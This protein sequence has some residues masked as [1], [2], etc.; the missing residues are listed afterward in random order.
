[1]IM[2]LTLAALAAMSLAG[3]ASAANIVL[4]NVDP[5]N[6]GFNDPTPATPVGGNMGTTVGQQRLIAYQRALELWGK[7]LRSDVPIVVRGS[8]A[9]LT[10]NATGGTLAQ[11]G[12][13]QVFANFPNA[14]LVDHWYGVA[15][16][17]SI[18]G[19]DLAPGPIDGPASAADDIVANFN[20]DVGKADCIAGP[21]WYY[22]LDSNPGPGQ[23]DFLDVFMHEV[24]HGLG[25]QNFVNEQTGANLAGRTDVYS[26]YTYD[27]TQA[28]LWNTMSAAQIRASAINNGKVVWTGPKVN[29][30]APLVLGPYEGVR[31]FGG[32]S[33]ELAFG[34]ATFGAAPSAATLDGAIVVGNDGVAGAGGGTATDGCE[35][36]AAGSLAGKV[37]LIDRGLC[38]FAV[39]VKNAQ[40]AGA[41]AVILANTLGRPE[42]EP[43]GTDATITIAAIGISQ[44]DGDAI[45]A[46]LGSAAVG[47]E[48]FT[49]PSRRAGTAEGLVRLYAPT[50]VA[51]GSSISH[52]DTVATPNLLMEP[53]A[54]STLRGAYTLDL[55]P[56]LMEDIGWKIETLKI[57][58]CDT[59]VP[60]VLPTGEMLHAQVDMCRAQAGNH[61]QFVS[62]MTRV[63]NSAKDRGFIT[64]S[65]M[66]SVMSCA[67]RAN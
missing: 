38:T 59:G 7:T 20:G 55:T 40:V 46:A 42:F 9:R 5:P 14:P 49:D 66:G 13:I 39:K 18:A 23:T 28:R 65:Q 57:S 43:G 67:A 2:R 22:G 11:A 17:N 48:Y 34:A 10:C 21:G 36:F 29:A 3:A 63:A 60:S 31:V 52:F 27:L 53:F 30:K 8:F 50:V 4:K 16:A 37:A 61:G 45:K 33:R 44:A 26:A 12:A 1:M 51:L 24:A 47:V 64:G 19:T 35:P 54:T 41:K 62:C 6:I 25:F 58:G 15:L 32:L 56:A